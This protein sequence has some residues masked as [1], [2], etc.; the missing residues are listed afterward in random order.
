M[1]LEMQVY[2]NDQ[3]GNLAALVVFF[4]NSTYEGTFL[5]QI[6]FG[7]PRL[8]DAPVNTVFEIQSPVDL[9]DFLGDVKKFLFYTGSTTEGDCK[10]NVTWLILP[11]TFKISQSQY[12]N[13]P[14]VLRGSNRSQQS[15]NGRSVMA[16]FDTSKASGDSSEKTD[17]YTEVDRSAIESLST[18]KSEKPIND[19][20]YIDETAE[21]EEDYPEAES[22]YIDS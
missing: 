11:D 12:D 10:A 7:N 8:K 14:S 22:S 2:F 9:H 13:F 16:N 6:G 17:Y 15:M 3:Y 21:Y 18:G 4:T 1:P 19:A 20:F 5:N